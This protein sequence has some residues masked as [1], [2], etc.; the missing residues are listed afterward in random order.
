MLSDLNQE[1]MDRLD[2]IRLGFN[3][4]PV[5]RETKGRK[6]GK[7]KSKARTLDAVVDAHVTATPSLVPDS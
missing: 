1:L 7:R 5:P 4:A 6:C 3:T 2:N